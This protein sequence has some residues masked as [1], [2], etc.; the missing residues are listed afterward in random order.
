[1]D[2]GEMIFSLPNGL[3]GYYLGDGAEKRLSEGPVN[4]VEDSKSTSGTPAVVN[5]ISCMACHHSGIIPFTDDVRAGRSV[6]LGEARF[7]VDQLYPKQEEMNELIAKD[8]Q[9]FLKAL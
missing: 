8:Q 7:K 6:P 5:A 1:H 3:Q 2:G 9:R 4:V